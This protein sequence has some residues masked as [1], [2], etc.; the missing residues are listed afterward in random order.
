MPYLTADSLPSDTV[1]YS[2]RV[3]NDFQNKAAFVGAVYELARVWNWELYGE[4]TPDEMAES[5]LGLY[6]EMVLNPG[7]CLVF[8]QIVAVATAA[9]PA[10]LLACDGSS[11]LRVDYPE[12]YAALNTAYITDANNFV[13][14]DLR[15]QFVYGA[16]NLAGVGN[17]AGSPT[18]TIAQTNLPSHNHLYNA[19]VSSVTLTGAG[20]PTPTNIGS[21]PTPSGNAGGGT[22]LDIMP[23]Y[24]RLLYAIV[25]L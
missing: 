18:K 7:Q 9:I 4:M 12:L 21:L 13:V 5:W 16:V 15:S 20:A 23:P 3:P 2:V 11:Y 22:A 1:C 8:G 25:A 10:N 19:P 24:T 6:N 17:T 14:P